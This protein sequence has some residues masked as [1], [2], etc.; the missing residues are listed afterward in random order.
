MEI[1][2][3]QIKH[4]DLGKIVVH[5]AI[6]KE[7]NDLIGTIIEDYSTEPKYYYSKIIINK[8]DRTFSLKNVGVI[9]PESIGV[10]WKE[11]S[12]GNQNFITVITNRKACDD[13]I[14]YPSAVLSAVYVVEEK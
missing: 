1:R 11:T 12:S 3:I 2:K 9:T 6:D 4:P 7:M 14:V 8:D 5:G 10:G 13:I